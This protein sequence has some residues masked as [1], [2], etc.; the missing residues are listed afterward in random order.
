M[1]ELYTS[2]RVIANRAASASDRPGISTED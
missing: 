1:I 2:R